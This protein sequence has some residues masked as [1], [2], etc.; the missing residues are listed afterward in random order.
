MPLKVKMKKLSDEFIYKLVV[1]T[2]VTRD[3]Q[4]DFY[5]ANCPPKTIH[6][7]AYV[8]ESLHKSV[9]RMDF[10]ELQKLISYHYDKYM[11]DLTSSHLIYVSDSNDTNR[12]KLDIHASL[13]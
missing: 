13:P 7:K 6:T 2:M 10:K 1:D 12:L 8:V 4:I 11:E 9:F 3:A 5:Y